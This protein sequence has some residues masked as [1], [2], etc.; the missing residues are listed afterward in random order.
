MRLQIESSLSG[1][2]IREGQVLHCTDARHDDRVDPD[3][4]QA[5]GAI[6]MVCVPLQHA[7]RAV[8]VLKVYD[9]RPFA[10]SEE[11][12]ATLDLL[13]GV[14]GAHMAHA[15]DFEAFR[16]ASRH[17]ALTGLLN[18]RSFDERLDAELHRVSR[19]GGQLALTLLDLDRFKQIND[20]GGHAA[21]DAVLR[22]VAANLGQLRAE[23]AAYRL[24]GDEFA[25]VLIETSAT[26]A[27]VVIDRISTNISLDPGCRG[28]GLSWG[29]ATSRTSDDAASILARADAALYDAKR[30]LSV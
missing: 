18:R 4:C 2:C 17:D 3:A 26:G 16:H 23:D 12:V 19:H 25:L 5:I 21:G 7:E 14:I 13:S 28:V 24:G 11:D 1:L 15:T 30:P 8:G 29:V 6:S 10:F 20:T 9:A 27:R 22:A